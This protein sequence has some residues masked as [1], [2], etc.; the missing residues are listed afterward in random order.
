MKIPY[1]LGDVIE[2]KYRV[3]QVL[4]QD[5]TQTTYE[6]EAI[7]DCGCEASPKDSASQR[8]R[9]K[10]VAIVPFWQKILL[11]LETSPNY[12]HPV[13]GKNKSRRLIIKLSSNNYKKIWQL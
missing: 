4:E 11:I 2:Q 3:I 5:R 13:E 8:H 1:Q 7:S 9:H 12:S 10:A 6:V